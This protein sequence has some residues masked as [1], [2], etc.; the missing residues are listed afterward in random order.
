MVPF[1]RIGRVIKR[2]DLLRAVRRLRTRYRWPALGLLVLVFFALALWGYKQKYGNQ[3]S[4]PDLVW[5]ALAVFGDT[6]TIYP[7]HGV[8]LPPYPAALQVAR[9]GAPLTL[10]LGG[11][12][13]VV[14]AFSEP[15]TLLQIRLFR[16]RHLIVCGLGQFGQRLVEAFDDRGQ[17]VVVVDAEPN[18]TALASCRERSIPV[19]AGDAT[20]EEVLR[21]A[22]IG[23]AATL[24]AVCGND[25][26]NAEIGM[27]AHRLI[28]HGDAIPRGFRRRTRRLQGFIQVGNDGLCQVL[29]SATVSAF[30]AGPGLPAV[31]IHYV[32]V[33][34]S[35]PHIL[36]RKYRECFAEQDGRSPHTVIVGTDPIGM[37]LVVGAA[38]LW[39]FDHPRHDSRLQVTLLLP[40]D[41]GVKAEDL[42]RRY[43]HLQEACDLRIEAVD[44]TDL[45]SPLPSLE[46][47]GSGKTTV[48]VCFPD[49]ATSLEAAL[50]MSKEFPGVQI[51]TIN[52]ERSA[53]F[54]LLDMVAK[55]QSLTAITTFPL[56]DNVCRPENFVDTL[57]EQIAKALHE[58]FLNNRRADGTYDP[59]KRPTHR[60]WEE[61]PE[62]G[63]ESNRASARGYRGHLAQFGYKVVTTDDWDIPM[64]PFSADEVDRMAVMEHERWCRWMRSTRRKSPSLV[65]WER[66]PD[67]EK[68]KNYQIIRELPKELARLGLTVV[69]EVTETGRRIEAAAVAPSGDRP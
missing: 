66:L 41:S 57:H 69:K 9:F 38:R 29:E 45:H 48:F 4:W 60:V 34:H 61:L 8:L 17:R 16:R 52:T 32:N 44:I 12:S 56:L 22:G 59:Q 54:T 55:D 7:A 30:S 65:P 19:V 6:T 37:R 5:A 20:S 68:A 49:E 3:V 43:P 67:S 10:I 64:P 27:M 51:V 26:L 28:E 39:Y 18:R 46:R 42:S 14:T 2:S 58:I 33:F 11:L 25:N 15:F 47:K 62:E 23:R 35:G 40:P 21:G 36:L 63:R 24:V 31:E 50:R 1:E 53:R 13:A